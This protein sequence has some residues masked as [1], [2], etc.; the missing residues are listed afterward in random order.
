MIIF[1]LILTTFELSI[2]FGGSWGSIENWLEPK[3][4]HPSGVDFTKLCLPIKKSPVHTAQHL[5]K[6]SLFNITNKI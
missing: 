4:E 2:I 1:R 3:T 6:N 5:S